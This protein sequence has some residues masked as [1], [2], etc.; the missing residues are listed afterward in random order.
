MLLTQD[1]AL[2]LYWGLLAIV[3]YLIFKEKEIFIGKNILIAVLLICTISV[4]AYTG[5]RF[6]NF[7]SKDQL[8]TPLGIEKVNTKLL[9]AME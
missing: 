1:L 4:V 7:F 3:A 5:Y 8:L 2:D 9:N 6:I